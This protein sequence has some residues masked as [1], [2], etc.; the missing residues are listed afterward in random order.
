[1]QFSIVEKMLN[2]KNKNLKGPGVWGGGG[3]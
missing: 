1:M 3:G 2:K